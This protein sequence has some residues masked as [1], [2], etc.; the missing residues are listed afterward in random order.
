MIIALL[1]MNPQPEKRQEV[2]DIIRSFR[3][4]LRVRQDCRACE[5]Y[6]AEG[7]A[8]EILYLEQWRSEDALFRHLQSPLYMRILEAME[9][10]VEAPEISFY[11][12][13]EI[14]GMEL[15]EKL[16]AGDLLRMKGEG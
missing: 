1:K 16:R 11:G 5:V 7:G 13:S 9:L 15:I 3:E 14:T 12:V 10:A 4:L 2:L 8:G 6:E